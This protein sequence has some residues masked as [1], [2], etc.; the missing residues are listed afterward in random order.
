[1]DALKLLEQDHDRFKE[2]LKQGEKTADD[3]HAERARLFDSLARDLQTHERMEEE[4]L[5]PAL[6]QHPKAVDIVL[7]GYEEHHLADVLVLELK[8]T[9]PSDETWAAKWK[10]LRESLEHHIEEEE[11]E[12]FKKAKKIFE[13]EELEIMGATMETIRSQER[14][15][16]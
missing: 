6:K 2:L 7:E 1:M 15:H 16:S 9:D 13:K 10:V 5:Y 8:Q 11:S 3:A 4:V 12:M 14:S